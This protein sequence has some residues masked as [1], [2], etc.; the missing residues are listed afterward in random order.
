MVTQVDENNAAVV[1]DTVNPAAQTDIFADVA[2]A[3]LPAVVST[4]HNLF[5]SFYFTII[6]V[7]CAGF[8]RMQLSHK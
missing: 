6:V 1:A 5:L 8:F 7:Y 3:Q 2:F 4:V